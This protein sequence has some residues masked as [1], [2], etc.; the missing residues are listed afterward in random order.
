MRRLVFD[1]NVC[2]DW[3]NAGRHEAVIFQR[4]AVRHLSAV[5]VMELPPPT[6]SATAS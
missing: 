2:I 1:T 6:P 3:I 5:V 4:E